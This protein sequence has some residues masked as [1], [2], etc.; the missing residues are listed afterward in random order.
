MGET[1]KRL[2]ERTLLKERRPAVGEQRAHAQVVA[3]E[4]LYLVAA[5]A[6]VERRV[7]REQL[8]VVVAAEQRE[9]VARRIGALLPREH[10]REL[11]PAAPAEF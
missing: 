8:L 9:R 3:D 6:R 11:T 4:R 10:F 5:N 7:E 1:L 2:C